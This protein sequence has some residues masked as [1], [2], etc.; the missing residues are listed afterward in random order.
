MTTIFV[1]GNKSSVLRKLILSELSLRYSVTFVDKDSVVSKGNGYELLFIGAKEISNAQL[2]N[3]AVILQK[4]TLT[5]LE[6][7]PESTAVIAFSENEK[8]MKLLKA[9]SCKIYTCGYH[10]QDTFSYTSLCDE[11]IVISLNR[12]ITALSG[13][14]IQPL[15]IPSEIPKG[16]DLYSFMA[17][18]ALRLLLDDYNSEIGTLY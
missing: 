10:K 15:E 2:E 5:S 4:D 3:A 6:A 16:A 12:E 18:T 7:F 11:N 13:K 14:K 1:L 9:S 8:Q 17:F